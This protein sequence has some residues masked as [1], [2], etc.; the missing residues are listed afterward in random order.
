MEK[1]NLKKICQDLAYA[2][3]DKVYEG[4][5]TK[6]KS[7]SPT[8]FVEY[9]NQNW[10]ECKPMWVEYFRQR[11]EHMG[12]RTTNRL[13]NFHKEIKA[14]LKPSLSVAQCIQELL[15]YDQGKYH[16]TTHRSIIDS[17]SIR[18]RQGL[19]LLDYD[20]L[21]QMATSYASY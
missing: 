19:N 14:Y 5:Y 10:H 18:Y 12:N 3:S 6:L 16:E 9:Y 13:E 15:H 8:E 21:Q 11:V 20:K 1:E 7:S 4:A 2:K 17:V